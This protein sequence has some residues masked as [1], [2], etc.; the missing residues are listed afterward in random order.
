M[1]QLS[2]SD[3]NG[4]LWLSVLNAVKNAYAYHAG[5][6]PLSQ[7]GL[8][9]P[10]PYALNHHFAASL[11]HG[12]SR[13]SRVPWRPSFSTFYLYSQVSSS[14]PQLVPVVEAVAQE[15]Q[16]D[17]RAARSVSDAVLVC[18]LTTFESAVQEKKW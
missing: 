2:P 6:V 13:E 18:A 7:L 17:G 14:N 5:T 15:L 16:L 3:P 1:R 10:G 8:K 9:V 11:H 4:Q 12:R